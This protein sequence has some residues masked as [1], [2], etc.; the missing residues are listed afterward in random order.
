LNLAGVS[1][2]G[3]AGRGSGGG[4]G[5]GLQG[6]VQTIE[7]VHAASVTIACARSKCYNCMCKKQVLQLHVQE[8]SV[9][10]ACARSKCYN[11]MRMHAT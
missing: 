1:R 3:V 9:T 6:A 5:G 11:C 10:I 8:A 2:G 7:A 4:E